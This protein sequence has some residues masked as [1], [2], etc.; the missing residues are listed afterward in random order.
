[1]PTPLKSLVLFKEVERYQLD[2]F[3][4]LKLTMCLLLSKHCD[5]LSV[6]LYDIILYSEKHN[7][8]VVFAESRV[9][10]KMIYTIFNTMEPI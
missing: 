8:T 1:M 9:S 5:R 4:L 7:I 10:I 6:V 3:P 2:F